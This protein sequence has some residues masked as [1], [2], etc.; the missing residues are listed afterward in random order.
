MDELG[1]LFS[2]DTQILKTGT[3]G[4]SGTGLGMILTK[5]LLDKLGYDIAIK[6]EIDKGTSFTIEIPFSKV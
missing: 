6:S 5:E 3:A 2:I 4:E 1:K